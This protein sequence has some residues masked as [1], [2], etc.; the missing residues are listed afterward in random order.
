MATLTHLAH[1][2]AHPPIPAST[3][4]ADLIAELDGSLDRPAPPALLVTWPREGRLGQSPDTPNDTDSIENAARQ[5]LARAL[6]Q[7]ARNVLLEPRREITRSQRPPSL[8]HSRR[9][10]QPRIDRPIR[11]NGIARASHALQSADPGTKE[12]TARRGWCCTHPSANH[13]WHAQA[14][15]EPPLP[16]APPSMRKARSRQSLTRSLASLDRYGAT[17]CCL[18]CD[19]RLTPSAHLFKQALWPWQRDSHAVSA[20]AALL[21]ATTGLA[22]RRQTKRALR[23][24]CSFWG[25]CI[26]G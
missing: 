26:V 11:L 24:G 18:T 20:M 13:N 10:S 12:S 8:D 14:Y 19:R 16:P 3:A 5:Y 1:A 22:A 15:I 6:R 25:G 4:N 17:G 9:R 23:M 2:C 21:A 7:L